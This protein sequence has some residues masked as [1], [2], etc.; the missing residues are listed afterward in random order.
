MRIDP[1]SLKL[2][3]A[4]VEQG[5]IAA[6]AQSNHIASA[7]VSKRISE[8][9][10]ALRTPLLSRTNKGVS[11]TPAGM[12]LLHLARRLLVDLDDIAVQM[13]DWSGG[14]RGQVRVFANISAITQFLPREIGDF[15]AR[16]PEVDV[17]LQERISSAVI[18]AVLDNEADVGICVASVPPPGIEVLPYHD[19]ELVLIVP[20]GHALAR[21][22]RMRFADAL[23]HDVVGLHTGSSINQQLARASLEAGRPLRLRIQ[24]T[25]YDALARMVEAGLGIGVMPKAVA[26]PLARSL[27]IVVIRL[28]EDWTRRQ[29]T[30]CVRSYEALPAAARLL[31]DHLRS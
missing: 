16:Y 31:V 5:S 3:V 21:R 28:D 24:V 14:T 8:L 6:A 26:Q 9:E 10:A 4:I 12:A 11:P 20:R 19:D 17:H 27:G 2:F 25:S 13:R 29:L 23:D 7:A 30:I 15:L 18:K 1:L 22:R